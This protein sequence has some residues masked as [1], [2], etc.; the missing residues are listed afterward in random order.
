MIDERSI[1]ELASF[2]LDGTPVLSLYLIVDPGTLTVQGAYSV[3]GGTTVTFGTAYTIPST[4]FTGT[5]G[6]AIGIMSTS[7]GPGGTFPATWDFVEVQPESNFAGM[8]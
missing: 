2:Q 5:A 3:D 8:F 4:W 1:Q 7:T 6:F